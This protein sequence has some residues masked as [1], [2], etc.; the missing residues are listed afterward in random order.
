MKISQNPTFAE[1]AVAR[2]KVKSQ[3]FDQLID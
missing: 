2:R 3:F 1:L